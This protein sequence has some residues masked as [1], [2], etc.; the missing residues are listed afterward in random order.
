LIGVWF[1]YGSKKRPGKSDENCGNYNKIRRI[2]MAEYS[3]E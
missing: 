3:P 2:G 1:D